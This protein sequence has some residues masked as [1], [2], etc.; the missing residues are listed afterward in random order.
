MIFPRAEMPIKAI[1]NIAIKSKDLSMI[2]VTKAVLYL[3]WV[4]STKYLALINS[5]TLPGVTIPNASE[6][7]V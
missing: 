5:P 2:T 1:N 4:L 3:S 7:V 6:I